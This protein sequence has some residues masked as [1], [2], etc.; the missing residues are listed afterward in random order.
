MLNANSFY[1]QSQWEYLFVPTCC[2]V[3]IVLNLFLRKLLD[4]F[5]LHLIKLFTFYFLEQIKLFT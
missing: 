2:F 1:S 4:E 3:S 5:N